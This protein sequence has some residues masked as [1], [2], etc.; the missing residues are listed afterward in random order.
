MGADSK[1]YLKLAGMSALHLAV[2]L[3][4]T[5]LAVDQLSHVYV[6]A[7]RLYMALAMVLPMVASM[8]IFM[9]KMFPDARINIGLALFVLVAFIA[10]VTSIR[11][12]FLIDDRAFLRSMIPH[13]SSAIL[14][15]ERADLEDPE[16]LTLCD[17]I[18]EA[19]EREISQMKDILSRMDG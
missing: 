4:L 12:Q 1:S 11:S 6:N 5:Y 8:L 13:H 17:G 18:V 7:N 15:C 9:P 2:M 14:M 16:I 10:V 3:A 19:Q